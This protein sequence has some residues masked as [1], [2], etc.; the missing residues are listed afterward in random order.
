MITACMIRQDE[1]GD[2]LAF[3]VEQMPGFKLLHAQHV[4]G[5]SSLVAG[6]TAQLIPKNLFGQRGEIF[7]EVRPNNTTGSNTSP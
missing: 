6:R 3:Q 1:L 5:V 4:L 7:T 2:H